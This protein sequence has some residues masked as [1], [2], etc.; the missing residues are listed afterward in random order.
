ML[1]WLLGKG[2]RPAK[3]ERELAAINAAQGAAI[4]DGHAFLRGLSSEEDQALRHRVAWLLASN[5]FSCTSDLQLRQDMRLTSAVQA[6]PLS[7]NLD[8][9]PYESWAESMICPRGFLSTRTERA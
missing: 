4:L 6:A 2:A 1:R 9:R 3:G 5:R 8:P 7:V